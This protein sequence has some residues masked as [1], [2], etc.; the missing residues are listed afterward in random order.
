MIN[1]ENDCKLIYSELK[2]DCYVFRRLCAHI[3][4][5][6]DDL[7]SMHT[8]C[9]INYVKKNRLIKWEHVNLDDD[10]LNVIK[11]THVLAINPLII[12]WKDMMRDMDCLKHN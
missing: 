9:L 11:R 5:V 10:Y 12:N 7:V 3:L 6:R 8:K 4:C 1:S 2:H